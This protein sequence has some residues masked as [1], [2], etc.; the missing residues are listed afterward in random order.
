MQQLQAIDHSPQG[1]PALR[2]A[3][4][5]S[6]G[7]LL[8]EDGL[9]RCGSRCDPQMLVAR[10]KYTDPYAAWLDQHEAEQ[11]S[12]TAT[13]APRRAGRFGRDQAPKAPWDVILV[14]LSPDSR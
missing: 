2:S 11:R 9:D 7:G 13:A 14:T 3:S 12:V 4:S 10:R 5:A 1:A 8:A 6:F